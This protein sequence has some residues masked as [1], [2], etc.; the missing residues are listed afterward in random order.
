[1][2]V[3]INGA[4]GCFVTSYDECIQYFKNKV[5]EEKVRM[6]TDSARD[7]EYRDIIEKT[8]EDTQSYESYLISNEIRHTTRLTK[9]EK[10]DNKSFHEILALIDT[11]MGTFIYEVVISD[12]KTH[13]Q[14]KSIGKLVRETQIK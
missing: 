12:C 13:N 7:R 4:V 6:S 1:M 3:R 5:Q 10:N 14:K 9:Q 2:N 8:S 11:Y